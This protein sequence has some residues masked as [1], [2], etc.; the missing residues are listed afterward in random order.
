MNLT[1]SVKLD[2]LITEIFHATWLEYQM[3]KVVGFQ[4]MHSKL[5]M[6]K[7]RL[8]ITC[9][10]VRFAGY[11][12]I[13]REN[14]DGL[15]QINSAYFANAIQW[16]GS[17]ASYLQ[18]L[19][20][21][22]QLAETIAHELAHHLVWFI[23]GPRQSGGFSQYHGPEFRTVMRA[24]GYAGDTYHYMDSGTARKV[25]KKMKVELI[26]RLADL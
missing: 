7:P 15:V 2:S 13:G 21:E 23:Y 3:H 14:P 4:M 26:E 19:R 18:R 11:W 9:K 1:E 6:V 20:C 16:N 25:A 10:P 17:V 24:L 22:A 8:E 12:S 5:V